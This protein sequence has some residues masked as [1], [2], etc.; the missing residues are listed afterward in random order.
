MAAH[1]RRKARSVRKGRANDSDPKTQGGHSGWDSQQHPQASRNQAELASYEKR[2]MEYFNAV[3]TEEDASVLV[4]IPDVEICE[5]FGGCWEE[6]Y[7]NA[8]D[9]LAACLSVPETIVHA[10]SSLDLLQSKHPDAQIIPIPVDEKIKQSYEQTKRFNVIFP[11][12][13]LTAVDE[14][15]AK[16]GWKRSA[17]LAVAAKEYIES[18]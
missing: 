14:Y 5:T 2:I 4:S 8:V 7:E 17:F 6:A 10:K 16:T 9:A 1:P 13:L 12:S 15:R 18:H 3:F 11:Q